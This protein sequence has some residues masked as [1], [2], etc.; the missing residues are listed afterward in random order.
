MTLRIVPTPL[1][2]TP[3]A[4]PEPRGGGGL[5][6]EILPAFVAVDGRVPRAD[7]LARPDVLV[8]TTGQQPG[9]FTGP[10][11]TI[12]KALSA[13]ALARTLERAWGR[14]VVPVFWLAGDDHDYAE[15]SHAAWPA[16]DGSLRRWHLP[17]RPSGAPLTPMYR[18]PLDPDAIRA[19][20]QLEADLDGAQYRAD[21]IAWL[22][23]HYR[24]DATVASAYA[25]ALAE[26]LA[27]LGIACFDPT[28]AAARA[29]MAPWFL[30]ALATAG[31]LDQQLARRSAELTAAGRDPE[32]AVGDG[33]TLVML[34]GVA[35]R[36]RLVAEGGEFVTRRGAERLTP[37]AV[38]RIAAEEPTRLSP[39]VLLRPAIEAA[40]L[41]TVAYVAGPGELRYL[42]LTPPVY[43]ALG[44]APQRPVPRWSGVLVEPAVDRTLARFGISLEELLNEGAA[45]DARIARRHFPPELTAAL[46]ELRGAA[47]RSFDALARGAQAIDPTLVRTMQGLLGRVRFSADQAERKL[48]RALKRR[49]A[50]ELAQLERARTAVRPDGRPQERVLIVPPWVARHGPG[51][52]E[53]LATEIER[54]YGAALEAPAAGR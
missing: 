44:V 53:E 49:E 17:E 52:L 3:S 40:I 31:P 4:A 21:V 35:G 24:P 22:R 29:A 45:L 36:D 34:E 26:L 6:P 48:V 33:A 1:S 18:T 25:G 38:E 37:Q 39:N 51:I 11:Y 9:L 7:D 13:R 19:L 23:R 10:A 15:A 42:A 54:W 16:P 5:S 46:E 8:V 50:T 30:R 20:D 14:P 12:H 28:H 47:D 43:E 27:P 41:P 2:A 32:V